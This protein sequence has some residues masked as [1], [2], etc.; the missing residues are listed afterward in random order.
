MSKVPKQDYGDTRTYEDGEKPWREYG[1]Y[2]Q[3]Y[4]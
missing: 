3:A 1:C 2:S 4:R